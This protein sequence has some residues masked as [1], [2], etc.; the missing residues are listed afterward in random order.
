MENKLNIT[1]NEAI[2][3]LKAIGAAL[4]TNWNSTYEKHV[5]IFLTLIT[6]M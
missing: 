1:Y 4:T 3:K 5:P 2:K 6:Q